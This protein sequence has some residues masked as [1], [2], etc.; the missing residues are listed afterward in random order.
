MKH[1]PKFA[2]SGIHGAEPV[3]WFGKYALDGTVGNWAKAPVGSTYT[4]KPSETLSTTKYR[5]VIDNNL[6][7][8]W[9]VEYGI[10]AE[11]ISVA[12]FTD[13]GSTAGTLI[14]GFTIPIGCT[15]K[16]TYVRNVVNW[17]GDVSATLVVGDGTDADRY[18]TGTPSL[19]TTAAELAVG[20][21]SGTVYHAAAIATVTATVTSA[22]DFT[23]V[24]T[25]G[26]GR[27]TIIILFE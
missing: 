4:Y 11:R 24:K 14:L 25:N 1:N 20:V 15:V 5:K 16:R 19:F 18:M 26:L 13:G 27:A 6:T 8:D 3:D 23:L 7:S 12:S 21:P 22:T 10:L 17:L 2:Q 9:V